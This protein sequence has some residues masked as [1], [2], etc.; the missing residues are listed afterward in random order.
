M[1]CSNCGNSL[2]AGASFCATCG[3][4]ISR[5]GGQPDGAQ[6]PD[7]GGHAQPERRRKRNTALRLLLLAVIL[8]TPPFLT[9]AI[10]ASL[11]ADVDPAEYLTFEDYDA[12]VVAATDNVG[13]AAFLIF[14]AV[15]SFA[16]TRVGY[17]WW[18]F[19]F[20]LI[21]V[22]GVIFLVKIAWRVA[23]LPMRDWPE[24]PA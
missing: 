14:L 9:F 10:A 21:P 8:A 19:V 24:R 4:R 12:A 5:A 2:T 1:F 6:A 13:G 23:N 16:L 3:Q 17:R 20:S 7:L 11:A 15:L 22:Y 18:D